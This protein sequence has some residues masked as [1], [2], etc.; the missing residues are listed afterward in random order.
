[1]RCHQAL[2]DLP[3]QHEAVAEKQIHEIVLKKAVVSHANP[4]F[5]LGRHESVGRTADCYFALVQIF[6]QQASKLGINQITRCPI[7]RPLARPGKEKCAKSK[8]LG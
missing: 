3:F 1:M 2:G 5:T 6:V 7:T 4:D 8:S